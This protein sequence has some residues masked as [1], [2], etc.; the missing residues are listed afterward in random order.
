MKYLLLI[1]TLTLASASQ[2]EEKDVCAVIGEL[3]EKVMEAHQAGVPMSAVMEDSGDLLKELAIE[4]Y[5]KPRY[6]TPRMQQRIIAEFRDAVYL[7]CVKE[8]RKQA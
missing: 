5:S 8:Q 3:A 1:L 7:V 4:A 2:A 6:S